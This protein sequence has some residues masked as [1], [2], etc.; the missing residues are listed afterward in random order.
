MFVSGSTDKYAVVWDMARMSFVRRLPVHPYAV[1]ALAIDPAT[2]DIATCSRSMLFVWDINGGLLASVNTAC[3]GDASLGAEK[4]RDANADVG[5][6]GGRGEASVVTD[7]KRDKA[8]SDN[9]GDYITAVVFCHAADIYNG[10]VITGHQS[11]VLR[12][13]EITLPLTP[14]DEIASAAQPA[15]EYGVEDGK[16]R[17]DIDVYNA[18]YEQ[19]SRSKA[20]RRRIK[21]TLRNE[22]SQRHGRGSP[23][24]TAITAIHTSRWELSRVWTGDAS[25]VVAEWSVLPRVDHWVPDKAVT[26]CKSCSLKFNMFLDRRHHCRYCGLVFCAKCS[27]ECREIPKFGYYEP[28]RVCHGCCARLDRENDFGSGSSRRRP[29]GKDHS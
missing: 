3:E 18:A 12:F 13:W 5:E 22:L 10:L 14:A 2:C 25:G 23:H 1:C 9:V 8:A 29:T 19:H 26:A 16:A 28:V 27:S 21:L 4:D 15:S 20:G 6:G 11:G 24:C 7:S 17:S